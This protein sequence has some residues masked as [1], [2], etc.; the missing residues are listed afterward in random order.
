MSRMTM[1]LDRV[2]R[3]RY[4]T[5]RCEDTRNIIQYHSRSYTYSRSNEVAPYSQPL[6]MLVSLLFLSDNCCNVSRP[7]SAPSSSVRNPLRSS[8]KSTS[9]VSPRNVKPSISLSRFLDRSLQ[10]KQMTLSSLN[11]YL[12]HHHHL[13]C[14]QNER[15]MYR[16]ERVL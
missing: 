5:H 14:Q 12:R 13:E 16:A 8:C 7:H 15:T 10:N 9:C 6:A 3:Y 4:R 11:K 2:L 1:K